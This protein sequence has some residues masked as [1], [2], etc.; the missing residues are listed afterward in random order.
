MFK[1]V[2]SLLARQKQT[3]AKFFLS[4]IYNKIDVSIRNSASCNVFKKVILKFIR[5][6]PNQVFNV[7]SSEGLTFLTRTRL[8][9]N[10]GTIF[11]I[12][13]I[14]VVVAAR[15]LKLQHI[16]SLTVLITIMKDKLSL[17]K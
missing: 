9:L 6:A 3:F 2:N 15:I 11:K 1:K 7:D 5:P 8:G 12:A 10:L 13:S 17:K 14:L 16:S 4:C